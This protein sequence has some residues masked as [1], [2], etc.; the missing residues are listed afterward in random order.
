MYTND[1][2]VA[3]PP[4]PPLTSEEQAD[5]DRLAAGVANALP[6][7]LLML[8]IAEH[9]KLTPPEIRELMQVNEGGQS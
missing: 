8:R 6:G 5:V 3:C 7:A 1:Q 2:Q 4:I 9:L